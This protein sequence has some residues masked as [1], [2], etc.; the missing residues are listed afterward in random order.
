MRIRQVLSPL[1]FPVTS[2]VDNVVLFLQDPELPP[3]V[4]FR[5]YAREKYLLRPGLMVNENLGG[6]SFKIIDGNDLE[7]GSVATARMPFLIKHIKFSITANHIPGCVAS[8][9][10]YRIEGEKERFI[11]VLHNPI[12]INIAVSDEPQHFDLQPEE[13]ILLEPGRYFVAFQIVNI[14]E[15]AKREYLATPE[16]ERDPNAMTISTPLCFRSSYERHP[17]SGITRHHPISIGISVKGLEYHNT[18]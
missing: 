3:A 9:N 18:I 1:F 11:N 7:L 10:V 4:F 2:P 16:L 5:G 13:T 14:D 6:A 17:A 15:D 8:V 12:F